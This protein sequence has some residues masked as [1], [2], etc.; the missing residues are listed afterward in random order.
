M[1]QNTL[2]WLMLGVIK[3]TAVLFF[4]TAMSHHFSALLKNNWVILQRYGCHTKIHMTSF[5]VVSWG[6]PHFPTS[7]GYLIP[8]CSF[9]HISSLKDEKKHEMKLK[10]KYKV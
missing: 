10:A 2:G 8:E 6:I 5:W 7:V 1:V 9:V 3:V 4:L